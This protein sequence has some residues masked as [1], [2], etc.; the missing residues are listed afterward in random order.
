MRSPITYRHWQPGDDDAVWEL[1]STGPFNINRDYYQKKFNDGYL[2]PEGVRLAFVNERVVGHVFGS[3]TYMY[4]EGK[5]QDFGMVTVMYVAP[6]MRRQGIATRLMRELNPYFE[7]KNYRGCILDTDTRE[8][9]QLYRKVGCQEVTREVR[10]QLSP[11]SDA[12]ELKWTSVNPE[13]FDVLHDIKKRWADQ[14]FPV[15]WNPEYPEVHQF[16]MKQYRVLRRGKS[17]V[18]YAKWDE[19]SKYHP[20]GLVRDPMVPDEDPMAVIA[21]VQAAIPAPRAWKTAEGSRYENPLR[22]LSCMLQ[23]TEKVEM[24]LAFGTEID[25]S[26]LPRTRPFW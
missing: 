7:R 22:S 16:N 25:W 13:D 24:L 18:G 19:P 14:N 17:I 21:S 1:L 3:E 20:Q 5:P 2:E 15:Y 11:R 9:Y 8:A 23:P 4:L 26:G 12:S 6:D 10:T